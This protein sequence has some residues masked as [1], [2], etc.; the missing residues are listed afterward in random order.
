MSTLKTNAIRNANASSDGITL[1]SDGTIAVPN[2][3]TLSSN[4]H[5]VLPAGT[6]AE[7]DSSPPNYSFR[8]NTTLSKLEFWNGTAWRVVS[9]EPTWDEENTAT[10]WWKNEGIT[11][12]SGWD[13]GGGTGGS[14]FNFSYSQG[15]STMSVSTSDS[16]FNNKKSISFNDQTDGSAGFATAASANTYWAGTSE[17]FSFMAVIKKTAQNSGTNLGDGLFVHTYNSG[18]TASYSY[19]LTGDHGW[20]GAYGE[21]FGYT[22]PPGDSYPQ[23]G[24]FLVRI[25]ANYS[26]QQ[27]LWY[28]AGGSSWSLRDSAT[29]IP[30]NF[31]TSGY[32]RISLANFYGGSTSHEFSGKIA[33][34]AYWKGTYLTDVERDR[35]TTY[36]KNKFNF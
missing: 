12:T 18:S 31:S 8:Y 3:L 6:T 32:D 35:M 29:G 30:S 26:Q 14:T 4:K 11:D 7:R 23:K 16:D 22:A 24:I 25:D 21:T 27:I 20:G 9:I 33:E 10:A 2:E 28:P 13:N 36:L 34:C 19:D 15:T 5:V 1:S 17:A